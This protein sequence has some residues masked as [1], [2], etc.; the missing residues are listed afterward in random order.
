MSSLLRFT[1]SPSFLDA[2]IGI[3]VVEL[4]AL[5]LYAARRGRGMPAGEAV[6]FLGAGLALLIAL[7]TRA[8]GGSALAFGAAM[9]VALVC[10]LWHVRQRWRR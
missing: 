7:R 8:A 1:A 5:L 6:A 3:V 4:A 9:T 2:V 10:H